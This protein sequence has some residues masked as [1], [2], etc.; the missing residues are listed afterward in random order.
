MKE[1]QKLKLVHLY[2]NEMN[3]YGDM[4]NIITFQKRCEWRGID[5]E[6]INIG[7][8]KITELPDGDIYFMGGGQDN[9]M[10]DVFDDLI[11]NKKTWVTSEV[12]KNKVFLLICGAFELFGKYFLDANGRTI[13][14]LNI[15]PIETK[16]P[17][18]KL[19]D[20]CLGNLIYKI[21]DDLAK[22]VDKFYPGLSPTTAVG[23][24]NHSGQVYFKDSVSISG[25]GEVIYGKGNNST[26]KI[27]GARMRN[28]FGSF[29]HGSFLPKNPHIADTLIGLALENKYKAEIK[30]KPLDDQIELKAHTKFIKR[31]LQ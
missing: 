28:V 7:K 30:L 11:V 17:S 18:E 8:G 26:E 20:R 19:S 1:K 22:S 13:E 16:A 5:I 24:E 6:I 3:I 4:G 21:N 23:F 10:Y 15:L 31:V 2:P 25:V 27:E 12:L 14:G 29:T 9:D